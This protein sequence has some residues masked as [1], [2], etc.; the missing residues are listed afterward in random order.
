MKQLHLDLKE[1][2]F[3]GSNDQVA[4]FAKKWK[5]DENDR[6]NSAS[7][8]SRDNERSITPSRTK[9]HQKDDYPHSRDQT[10][11][12]FPRGNKGNITERIHRQAYFG[13]AG[14]GS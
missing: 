1:L 8:R 2:G 4:I 9:L 6:V 5:V 11:N 14:N 13:A 7:N 12:P 3:E 10:R